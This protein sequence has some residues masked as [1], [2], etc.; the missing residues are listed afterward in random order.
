MKRL[1][2]DA[3]VFLVSAVKGDSIPAASD[4]LAASRG[5]GDGRIGDR[6]DDALWVS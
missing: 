4:W 2:P 3:A 1:A 6:V 5:C